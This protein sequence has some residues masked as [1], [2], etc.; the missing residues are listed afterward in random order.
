MLPAT[1]VSVSVAVPPALSMPPPPGPAKLP[2]TVQSVR[3]SW[4]CRR[5]VQAAAVA[6]GLRG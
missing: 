5:I 4:P 3:V 1:I 6:V 2:L